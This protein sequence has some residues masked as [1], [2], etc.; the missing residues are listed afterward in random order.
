MTSAGLEVWYDENELGGGDAWDQKIRR[1]IKECDY[2]MALIS[3]QTDARHEGY[4]RREWRLAIDRALDMADDH[5]FLLPVVIDNTV[6]ANA[7]VPEKFHSVQWL[8][9]PGGQPNAGLSALCSRLVSGKPLEAPP[10]IRPPRIA[11]AQATLPARAMPVFPTE[12]PGQRVKFWVEVAAWA[13]KSAWMHFQKLPRFVRVIVYLWLA[14]FAFEGG[15]SR[16]KTVNTLSPEE[17]EKIK[18]IAGHFQGIAKPGDVGKLGAEIAHAF[19]DDADPDTKNDPLLAIPFVDPAGAP[20]DQKL[21][22]STFALLYGRISISHRGKVGLSR[23]SIASLDVNGALEKARANHSAYVLFGGIE[24]K[25][26]AKVL[27]VEIATVS[28]GAVVWAK[29]YPVAT[30]E[31]NTIAEEAESK[32]PELDDN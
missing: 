10:P 15:H 3:A 5:T 14:F 18:A 2:F 27:T 13:L 23:D 9:V 17:S 19:D 32:I 11:A 4:F 20:D 30:S 28:D 29:S 8:R 26:G 25:G 1:Q 12:E 16:T 22:N 7:R 24:N 31:P 6:Q 21:A